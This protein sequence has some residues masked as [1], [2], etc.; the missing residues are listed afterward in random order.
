MLRSKTLFVTAV[1]N[2]VTLLG[3]SPGFSAVKDLENRWGTANQSY[4][5][6]EYKKTAA[7]QVA[8]MEDA[9]IIGTVFNIT[10]ENEKWEKIINQIFVFDHK[11]SE[12]ELNGENLYAERRFKIPE[13]YCTDSRT[14]AFFPSSSLEVIQAV[15]VKGNTAEITETYKCGFLWPTRTMINKTTCELN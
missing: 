15:R 7:C 13:R 3:A 4:A 11:L 6:N 14:G 1:L 12:K 8:V 9:I 5:I 10:P 2:F